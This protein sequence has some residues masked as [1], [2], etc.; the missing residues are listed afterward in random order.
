MVDSVTSGKNSMVDAS[1]IRAYSDIITVQNSA[2]IIEEIVTNKESYCDRLVM[3]SSDK[4]IHV[5]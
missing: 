1:R 3:K 4:L 5:V 2:L